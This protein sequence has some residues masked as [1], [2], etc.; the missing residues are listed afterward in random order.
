MEDWEG[1]NGKKGDEDMKIRGLKI[2]V[3]GPTLL[4][5]P[6]MCM[7]TGDAHHSG[8][9]HSSTHQTT[10]QSS[11]HELNAGGM[12]GHGWMTIGQD[13]PEERLPDGTKDL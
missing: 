3:I 11:I 9:P 5:L 6:M 2:M 12:L 1:K 13:S 4:S 7:H 8:D 10:Y